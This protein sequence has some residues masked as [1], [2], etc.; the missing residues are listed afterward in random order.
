MIR[1]NLSTRPFYNER[2]VQTWL[3][4]IGV[5][6]LAA[7][8]FNVARVIR[9]SNSDTQLGTQATTDEARV[10]DLRTRATR[11]R[12]S[13]D[14]KQIDNASLEAKQA[15]DLIDRRTFSWTEL[16]NRFET[17]LPDDV[18]IAAVKPKIDAKKGFL[19]TIAVLAR[20]VGDVDRFLENLESTGAFVGVNAAEEHFDEQGLLNAVIEAR[21]VPGAGK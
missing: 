7:T 8:A 10:A 6:V 2:A 15:N 9:Y 3:M 20:N 21:Y 1:S 16:F 12:A 14:S 13:V 18:R 11:L 17:T 4:A 19:L 5:V